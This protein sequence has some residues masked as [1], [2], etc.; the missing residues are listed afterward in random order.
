[1]M[2]VRMSLW[3][4]SRG[5]RVDT[6]LTGCIVRRSVVGWMGGRL[7]ESHYTTVVSNPARLLRCALLV[8]YRYNGLANVLQ[9]CQ[10]SVCS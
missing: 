9:C 4:S 3:R 10:L 8:L 5:A 1:M 7:I 6:G 2:I